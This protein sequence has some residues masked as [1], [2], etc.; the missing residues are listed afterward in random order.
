LIKFFFRDLFRWAITMFTSRS[1]SSRSITPQ[2]SKYWTTY[3]TGP[4]G[5]RQTVLMD[6]S[7]VP[8]AD[9]DF[10]VL[11][12]AMDAANHH[13]TSK[14]DWTFDPGRFSLACTQSI[15]A[16]Q[17]I[18]NNSGPKAN[19][20][21]L[22]G[23]GFCM[24]DNPNDTVLL[25]LKPPPEELQISLRTSYAGFFTP[26]GTWN[27]DKATF[28]LRRMSHST[29]T[30][31]SAFDDL[32]EPLLELLTQIIRFDRGL[33]F[34]NLP[35]ISPYLKDPSSHGR[36]YLP[37]V[38]R[39]IVTSL[40]PKYQKLAT[41]TA[42]LPESAQNA[43]QFQAKIYRD[44]Q[45]EILLSTINGLR[46]S[47]RVFRP[48]SAE[49]PREEI[50]RM[51]PTGSRLAT[52]EEAVDLFVASDSGVIEGFMAGVQANANTSDLEQLR[53]AGWEEDAWV[54]LLCYSWLA[55]TSKSSNGGGQ[56]EKWMAELDA[57][58][59][60]GLLLAPSDAA[61]Q[62]VEGEASSE[63]GDMMTI[64]QRAAAKLPG[65]V[66]EDQRWSE[67][68][69]AGFGGRV[70]KNES[71]MMMVQDVSGRE[72]ARLVTYLHSK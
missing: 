40:A 50:E 61:T 14:V 48:E 27:S 20:E 68:L 17:E 59:Q 13:H 56:L 9:L 63:A 49:F 47:L 12:P 62:A 5:R 4:D 6:M 53:L 51:N 36:R 3:K 15:E 18:N 64:V 32:P 22:I 41:G 37:F 45:A 42:A 11:F 21:L 1:F 39:M 70:L 8:S 44:G 52:L 33:P 67:R 34:E 72:E 43:K 31:T 30:S 23:Y 35:P 24:A 2:D 69:I 10:S 58:Y 29:P 66:W 71:F 65:S 60:P 26:E 55:V 25:T 19:D 28:K 46:T 7:H 16:G 57:E 38:A 54:L